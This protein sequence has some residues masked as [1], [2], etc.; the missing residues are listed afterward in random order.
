MS[1]STYGRRNCVRLQESYWLRRMAELG[2]NEADGAGAASTLEGTWPSLNDVGAELLFE[3]VLTSCDAASRGR[4]VLP[5]VRSCLHGR[6]CHRTPPKQVTAHLPL[7][8]GRILSAAH[9]HVTSCSVLVVLQKA[10]VEHFA[11]QDGKVGLTVHCEDTFG[12]EHT[13]LHRFWTNS[14]YARSLVSPS[15]TWSTICMYTAVH[16]P[17]IS[18][19]MP[20]CLPD[21]G[22]ACTFLRDWK[23][24]YGCTRCNAACCLRPLLSMQ[25]THRTTTSAVTALKC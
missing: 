10:A 20:A 24:Y 3:K 12:N 13:I 18:A 5:K 6:R 1:P 14:K 7:P 16:L 2:G 9:P 22:H 8:Y 25:L 11:C 23:A 17:A 21:P 19:I 15:C 4:I